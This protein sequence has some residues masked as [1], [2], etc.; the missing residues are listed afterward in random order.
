MENKPQVFT[1]VRRTMEDRKPR[2]SFQYQK[3]LISPQ[4]QDNPMHA[5][6]VN[7]LIR[8]LKVVYKTCDVPLL[9]ECIL[10]KIA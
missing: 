1:L 4:I 6:D 3:N 5:E 10:R 9:E 2:Y 7:S 8:I